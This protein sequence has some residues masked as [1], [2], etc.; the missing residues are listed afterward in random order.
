[1]GYSKPMLS[2]GPSPYLLTR[3][4]VAYGS[5]ST[6]AR[7]LGVAHGAAGWI[8]RDVLLV[9]DT[10][11]SAVPARCRGIPKWRIS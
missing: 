9:P 10:V 5:A 3:F 2:S 4:P 8:G 1:M 7:G 6:F 11:P